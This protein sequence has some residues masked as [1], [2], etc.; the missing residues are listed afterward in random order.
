[1]AQK[2]GGGSTRNGRDSESK[3]LGVKAYRR[4]ADPGRFNHRASARYN[5]SSR[6]K[7][8]HWQRPYALCSDQRS[9]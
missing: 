3:R 2:K 1:M 9:R 7:R 6:N 5:V 4:R 8:G